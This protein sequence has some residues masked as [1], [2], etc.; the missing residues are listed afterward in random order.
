MKLVCRT[1]G[2]GS[3]KI[4]FAVAD[5]MRHLLQELLLDLAWCLRGRGKQFLL[6]A[7]KQLAAEA[8]RRFAGGIA[9]VNCRG[10]VID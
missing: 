5:D 7:A 8:P 3:Q 10:V 9:V 1:A 4:I 6:Y 2:T